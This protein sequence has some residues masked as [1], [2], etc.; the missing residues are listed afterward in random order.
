[1]ESVTPRIVEQTSHLLKNIQAHSDIFSRVLWFASN[2]L[3][4]AESRKSFWRN[5]L[6]SDVENQELTQLVWE[7]KRVWIFH[8][9]FSL[10][11]IEVGR[12]V[13]F[14]L[15][16]LLLQTDYAYDSKSPSNRDFH[17]KEDLEKYNERN[18]SEFF[19]DNE[20][21]HIKITSILSRYNKVIW[22][23]NNVIS[24]TID[25]FQDRL[26][27]AE[28]CDVNEYIDSYCCQ[29][30]YSMLG[31]DSISEKD[32]KS[33]IDFI[34]LLLQ[35]DI[36]KRSECIEIKECLPQKIAIYVLSERLFML[37]F[38][39]EKKQVKDDLLDYYEWIGHRDAI[40]RINTLRSLDDNFYSSLDMILD[41][42]HLEDWYNNADKTHTFMQKA[43]EMWFITIDE[44]DLLIELYDD[45]PEYVLNEILVKVLFN[46]DVRKDSD[47]LSSLGYHLLEYYRNWNPK[48]YNEVLSFIQFYNPKKD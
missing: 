26:F 23:S 42:I 8:N 3:K 46:S 33:L 44:Y 14:V 41:V 18:K 16:Q 19:D 12:R 24:D 37:W 22:R 38:F 2:E 35:E 11:G 30:L 39:T 1:M 9:D 31:Q 5:N 45:D 32:M 29:Q 10:D 25:N 34:N 17:S 13:F 47:L 40:E 36:L 4:V 21:L 6:F 15:E 27:D 7:F 43:Q 20:E 28:F 48:T